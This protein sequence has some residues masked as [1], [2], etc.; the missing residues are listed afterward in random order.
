MSELVELRN[1]RLQAARVEVIPEPEPAPNTPGIESVDNGRVADA[2]RGEVMRVQIPPPAT[3]NTPS[4][5]K[6][7]SVQEEGDH[8]AGPKAPG[9][10]NGS[11]DRSI[12][13][14]KPALQRAAYGLMTCPKCGA[15]KSRRWPC[16][17]CG[18][19][20][21]K[22]KKIQP[23]NP[24]TEPLPREAG[25]LYQCPV[26]GC[27]KLLPTKIGLKLHLSRKH[28]MRLDPGKRS[29]A[30]PASNQDIHDILARIAI[31]KAELAMQEAK[32]FSRA[33]TMFTRKEHEG[34]E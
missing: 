18:N 32:L 33:F 24:I 28:G 10:S 14:G 2:T 3:V 8:P 12:G 16:P 27:N 6:A 17:K 22:K 4:D 11:S 26:Q 1:A 34:N 13:D 25:D 31:L 5:G 21:R 7:S 9:N 29:L 30:T 15:Q 23:K 20:T 19:R